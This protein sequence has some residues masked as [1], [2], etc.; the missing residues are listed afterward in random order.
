VTIAPAAPSHVALGVVCPRCRGQLA[1]RTAAFTCQRCRSDFPVILGIPDFRLEPDPWIGLEDDREKARQLEARSRGASL[2]AMVRMYWSMT[3]GT[4]P[5]QA[6]RFVDHVL[7]AETRSREWLGRLDGPN[8]RAD[9]WLD[10]G[11]GTGD[12]ACVAAGQ[13]IRAVGIDVAMRWL[14]VAR[15]RAELS[16]VRVEFICANAEHLPFADGS[17]ARVASIG[18]IE[19]CRNADRAL[20]EARRVL[21]PGGDPRLRTVNRYTLLREPH[22]GV[23]GVGLVPRRF[24]DRYV[25]S[26]G[27]LGYEHHRPLSARELRRGMSRAGFDRVR[28]DPAELL[29]TERAKLAGVGW[30]ASVYDRARRLPVSRNALRWAAPLLEVSGV[31]A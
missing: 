2:E 3:P 17:F 6:A 31:A 4:P 26:R 10:V 22:V 16:G 20:A 30:A 25:R 14:V 28:V 9:A 18:T 7:T 12:L 19:H 29:E 11:T 13:G 23:W 21:A 24:A 5:A 1:S 8:A 15:R 27:G